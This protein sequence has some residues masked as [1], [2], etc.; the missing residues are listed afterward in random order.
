LRTQLTVKIAVYLHLSLTIVNLL[1][2]LS[3]MSL[4]EAPRIYRL[5][6]ILLITILFEVQVFGQSAKDAA[7]QLT[8]TVINAPASVRLDWIYQTT[9]SEYSVWRR[10][11]IEGETW[12]LLETLPNTETSFLDDNVTVNEI[13]EYRIQRTSA[14]AANG[15]ITAAIEVDAV[16]NR[17]VLLFVY[18]TTNA[19]QF[20]TELNQTLSDFEGDGWKVV[21]IGINQADLVPDVKAKIVD[22]YSLS[23]ATTHSLFLFGAVPVAYSGNIYPDG[24]PDHNGAWPADTYYGDMD[25]TWTDASIDNTVA[26]GSTNDNVPGDGKFDQSY[27]ASDLELEV[28]RVDFSALPA[29]SESEAELLR[30]YLQKDH[31]YRH[32]VIAPRKR[33]LIDDNFGY[34]GGE[35]FSANGWKNFPTLV[36]R[37]SIEA[38]D[39]SNALVNNSYQWSYGC[40]AGS[41]TS[42]SGVVTT[43]GFANTSMNTI[44]S[45]LFGSYFGDWNAPNNLMRSAL[46]SGTVLTCAWAGRPNWQV[47]HMAI[48]KTIGFSARLSQNNSSIYEYN[49]GERFVHTALLGDPTLRADVVAPPS[50]VQATY[51]SGDAMIV[52]DASADAVLGYHVFKKEQGELSFTQLTNQ[53]ETTLSFTDVTLSVPNQPVYMV[54]ALKLEEAFSGSYYNLSQGVFDTL[55][56]F[57]GIQHLKTDIHVSV[58]PNP[59]TEDLNVKFSLSESSI[60]EIE[61][62]D[63]HG[64]QALFEERNLLRGKQSITFNVNQLSAGI[65]TLVVQFSDYHT[66]KK[67]AK[68]N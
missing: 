51:Q 49:Y 65:Y 68:T 46:G 54:R 10:P 23:P 52:W 37:D 48:G 56:V 1:N 8:A 63:F 47:H 13:Y 50:N 11:L 58:Y 64:R 67:F 24:H 62:L 14:P 3:I 32:K 61:V 36:G 43:P 40:G 4:S 41:V 59:V 45:F 53:P 21:V 31:D 29:F 44:F 19:N 22:A 25:G 38:I 27:I 66:V 60:V 17:G 5:I 9:T 55:R 16:V 57:V 35:A 26:A 28:G 18:D 39:F 30:N 42:C 6:C 20:E 12:S 2:T 33:A 15:Y 7:I 34:F